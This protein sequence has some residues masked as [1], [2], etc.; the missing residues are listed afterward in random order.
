MAAPDPDAA[1]SSVPPPSTPF[2]PSV[3]L[4]DLRA[5]ME[6][7]VSE[8][9][10]HRFHT[11]RNVF[12]ALTGEVGE[13]AECLQW[14]GEVPRGLPAWPDAE[15]AALADEL[16][17]VQLYLVRL[18][19]LCGVDLGAAVLRKLDKNRAKYPAERC[20]GS[21][22]KYTAYA[23][24]ASAAGAPAPAPSPRLLLTT[25]SSS[26]GGGGGGEAAAPAAAPPPRMLASLLAAR[27]AAIAA[28]VAADAAVVAAGGTGAGQA[29]AVGRGEGR[30]E[31][32]AVFVGK[33]AAAVTCSVL[34]AI[35][36]GHALARAKGGH[37]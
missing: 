16:S 14:K 1:A 23:A 19:D 36:V 12:I 2:L 33:F 28:A 4:E 30:L 37:F 25:A 26:A 15:R 29:L 8:R 7:F 5:Q 9:D 13:I 21:S 10:W 27:D 24:D 31:D 17:D 20:R 3:T 18:S 35:A 32:F 34:G 22:A 6:T 11:P